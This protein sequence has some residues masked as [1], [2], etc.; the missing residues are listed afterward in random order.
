[1]PLDNYVNLSN[2]KSFIEWFNDLYEFVDYC[3]CKSFPKNYTY[4]FDQKSGK[5]TCKYEYKKALVLK[6][7]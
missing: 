1:M 6:N 4:E 3:K 5:I 7:E 2:S